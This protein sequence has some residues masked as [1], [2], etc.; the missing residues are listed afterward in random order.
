MMELE[1]RKSTAQTISRMS[2]KAIGQVSTSLGGNEVKQNLATMERLIRK[3][4]KGAA[5]NERVDMLAFCELFVNGYGSGLTHITTTADQLLTGPLFCHLTPLCI[6]F[7]VA[8]VVGYT[9]K[10][11]E[12]LFNSAVLIDKT[13]CVLANYQ[14][15]HLWGE[16][17]QRFFQHGEQ[18]LPPVPFA[19]LKIGLLI[20]FDVEF[21]E[22]VRT[23][24][25]LGADL[26]IV[27]L[28]FPLTRHL[29]SPLHSFYLITSNSPVQVPT[30]LASDN[31]FNAKVTVPS[32]FSSF[33]PLYLH[34]P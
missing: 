19:N 24:A 28:H 4:G 32:R 33:T 31:G 13:G 3:H 23:L 7:E 10:H 6:E 11:N 5:E 34:R 1:W 22:T 29:H 21:P 14:K 12:R 8:V 30:A 15:T 26:V 9:E 20:C 27:C 16:M 2:F 17:E 25:K 18:L